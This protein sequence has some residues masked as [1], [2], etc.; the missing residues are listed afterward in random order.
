MSAVNGTVSTAELELRT[1]IEVDPVCGQPVDLDSYR[2]DLILDFGGRLY[3]FCGRGCMQLF[4]SDPTR[5]ATA[6]RA[7]P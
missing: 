3:A 2:D 7:E 1:D 4:L 6:G 5:F